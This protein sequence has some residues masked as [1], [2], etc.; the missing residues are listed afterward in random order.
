MAKEAG[1]EKSSLPKSLLKIH[2]VICLNIEVGKLKFKETNNIANV[3]QL[4]SGRA[5]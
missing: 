2:W 5:T 1:V 3:S 4:V